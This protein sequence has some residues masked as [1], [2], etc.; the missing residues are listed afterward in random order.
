MNAT[1]A[2]ARGHEHDVYQPA[3]RLPP[4]L[5]AAVAVDSAAVAAPAIERGL[6]RPAIGELVRAARTQAMADTVP[7]G[8]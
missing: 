2:A 1:R 5:K 6:A 8:L 7:S 3:Q 4:L